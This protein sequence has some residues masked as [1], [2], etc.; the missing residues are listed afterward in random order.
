[1]AY[2]LHI[3]KVIVL[4]L[5]AGMFTTAD[6]APD[7][8]IAFDS[9]E[10]R[11]ALDTLDLDEPP[12]EHKEPLTSYFD[13]YGIDIPVPHYVGTYQSG[14]FTLTANVFLPESAKATVLAVH[15]YYDNAGTLWSIISRSISKGYAVAAIDL[16]GHGLSSGPRAS[17]EDFEQYG[18]AVHDF[19]SLARNACPEPVYFVGHSTGC[20]AG[21]EYM[22]AFPEH[23]IAK[24]V[25]LAPLVRSAYFKLSKAGFKLL[26]PLSESYPRWKRNCT[27]DAYLLRLLREDPLAY[28]RFPVQWSRAYFAWFDRAQHYG[29]I[30]APLLVIQGDRDDTVDWRYNLPF[31]QN[32]FVQSRIEVI[33]GARH[34]LPN[35]S[36]NYRE[37]MLKELTEFLH[38]DG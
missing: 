34:H 24:A 23:R 36:E 9:S 7:I 26:D 13:H 30:A 35:E 29:P 16:P 15:G 31:L 19:L 22:H 27:T 4:T 3:L 5:G 21:I 25:F 6:T 28:G 33:P 2:H 1:M 37:H 14:P 17:I 18:R 20:A 12:P 10:V 8:S 32:H 11:A 38:T